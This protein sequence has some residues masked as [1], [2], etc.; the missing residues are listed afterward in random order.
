MVEVHPSCLSEFDVVLHRV[1]HILV[2]LRG[3]LALKSISLVVV[4]VITSTA[5][6]LHLCTHGYPFLTV[7]SFANPTMLG[8]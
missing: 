1:V 8:L 2:C 5:H 7:A 4:G 6:V 3:P